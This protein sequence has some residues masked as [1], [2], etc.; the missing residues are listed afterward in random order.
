MLDQSLPERGEGETEDG[1]ERGVVGGCGDG[2]DP[3]L[4]KP[5]SSPRVPSHP[6]GRAKPLEPS[7]GDV[8]EAS[9]GFPRQ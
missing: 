4:F 2:K 9:A 5:L 3:E 6:F 8:G 1:P 7:S